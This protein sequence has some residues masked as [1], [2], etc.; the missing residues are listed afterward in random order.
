MSVKIKKLFNYILYIGVL[1]LFFKFV[2]SP[3]YVPSESMEPTIMTNDIVIINRLSYWTNEPQ[4]NEII[5]FKHG[6]ETFCK[7]II[8]VGGDEITFA[9]GYVYRNGERV[10]EVFLDTDT[11][12]YCT[13]SFVVPEEKVFVLGDNRENSYDS[14]YW[15]NPYVDISDIKGELIVTIP[16]HLI[17]D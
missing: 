3:G 12:T 13:R 2:L 7:R 6:E 15:E 11:K 1:I 9:D 10:E 17:V 8:G 4:V 16:F 14:R 5:S